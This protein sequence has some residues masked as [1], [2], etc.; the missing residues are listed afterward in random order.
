[1]VKPR[2]DCRLSLRCTGQLETPFKLIVAHALQQGSAVACL[3]A[4]DVFLCKVLAI[5]GKDEVMRI[6]KD[7]TWRCVII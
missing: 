3:A 1:M 2:K 7:C 6:R 4:L 5:M